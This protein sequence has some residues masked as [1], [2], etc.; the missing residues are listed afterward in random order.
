MLAGVRRPARVCT[1][2]WARSWQ[3]SRLSS[4]WRS[5]L[6]LE[7]PSSW[8]A[9][10][11]PHCL[12]S[13]HPTQVGPVTTE[14]PCVQPGT[15][16]AQLALLLIILALPDEPLPDIAHDGTTLQLCNRDANQPPLEHL[17]ESEVWP[18]GK[19][20]VNT[21]GGSACVAGQDWCHLR[22]ELDG[23]LVRG[24]PSRAPPAGMAGHGHPGEPPCCPQATSTCRMTC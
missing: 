16:V 5:S 23:S 10:L 19:S 4:T 13:S 18:A 14:S 15:S 6:S 8:S 17:R 2:R 1:R 12:R 11:T 9:L 24:H 7:P 22:R 3:S 20:G 21:V